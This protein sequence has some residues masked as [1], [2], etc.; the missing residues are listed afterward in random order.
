MDW[1]HGY[2]AQGTYTCGF[3]RELAPGWI[4]F[5]ALVKGQPSPRRH[6]AEPF[7]YLELGSGMGLGLCLLA[8]AHPEGTF[9]GV[10]FQ[11]DHI[12][13]S[14]RLCEAMQLSNIQFLEADFLSLAEDPGE[15][16]GRH[17][18]V[19]AH[20]IATW[21]AQPIRQAL[22]R[23]AAASLR[24]GGLFYCSYN[25][26][27]GWLGAFP[28]QQLAWLEAQRRASTPSA[29]AEGVRQAATTLSALLGSEE[30]PSALALSL[31]GLRGRLAGLAGLDTAY[32]VQEYINAGWQPLSVH[33]FHGIAATEKLRF[34][35]SAT[36]PDNFAGLLPVNVR[37]TVLAET[38][39]TMRETLQDLAINQAFR[40]DLFSRGV[41]ELSQAE[42]AA[43]FRPLR[44]RLQEAPPQTAYIFNSNFGQITGKPELYTALEALLAA[45]P[46]SF[47]ALQDQLNLSLP[48]LAQMTTLLLHAGRLGLDRGEM[49]QVAL[50][51]CSRAHLALTTLQLNDRP[52]HM[53]PVASLGTAIGFS[54]P[55]ALIEQSLR[56]NPAGDPLADLAAGLQPLGRSLLGEPADVL[57]AYR[58]RRP[59]LVA[60]GVLPA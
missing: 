19:V 45:G 26:L 3:Y 34:I 48:D 28:L 10:D 14:Q 25:T 11:P 13:H 8:A 22:L 9:I 57:A 52:Y 38:D 24:P 20:G 4:D 16:I 29:A 37:D 18:Y 44:L 53:R 54:L 12:L 58:N 43:L 50:E 21:I 51:S 56:Q 1:Q 42:L 49:A 47:G 35:G 15:L 7:R 59:G 39:A 40:R 5:A 55:E 32:T 2:H 30:E 23:L 27:P 60:L 6:P 46:M 41:Y 31:P 17:H 33:H 36:L